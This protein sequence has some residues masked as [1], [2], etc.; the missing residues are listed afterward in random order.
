MNT[1]I[2]RNLLIVKSNDRLSGVSENFNYGLGDVSLD[3]N[4]IALKSA[5][6]PHTYTNV[7]VNN[8]QLQ[9]ETG[10]EFTLTTSAAANYN[11]NGI[12]FIPVSAGSYTLSTLISTLNANQVFGEFTYDSVSNR[13]TFTITSA[14]VNVNGVTFL[15]GGSP[16]IISLLGF[17]LPVNCPTGVG[18]SIIATN[19]PTYSNNVIT[20]LV[21]PPA[22]YTATTLL[23]EIVT[24]IQPHITGTIVGTINSQGQAEFTGATQSWRFNPS[25]IADLIG[26]DTT[27]KTFFTSP[28]AGVYG[29]DLYGTRNLYIASNTLSNGYNALEANGVKSSIL[30]C[31]PVCSSQGGID[32]WEQQYLVKKSYPRPI[33]V[34]NFD[35]KILDD[36]GLPVPLNG[37]EVVLVF[38]IWAAV[39]L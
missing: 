39:K 31:V 22:Q 15:T 29:F 35:I 21:V 19:A 4:S 33:N 24:L 5:S 8:N 37:A 25:P 17:T 16:E 32:K 1:D 36:E 7:N 2:Q 34:T 18:S 13:V 30:G 27:V 11:V 38:E 12:G 26:W 14:G 10:A 9:I 20:D 6:I 3:I 28:V 23:A